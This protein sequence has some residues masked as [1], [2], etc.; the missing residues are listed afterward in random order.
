MSV[1]RASDRIRI[2]ALLCWGAHIVAIVAV[3][4]G[5]L[6][7]FLS[8]FL[9]CSIAVLTVVA[10]IQ[11][12]QRSAAFGRIFWRLAA[13]GFSI[14]TFGLL[15]ATYVDNFQV[16]FGRHTWLVEVFVNAWTAPLVMCLFLDPETEPGGP[17]WR[18][19]LDFAQVGIVFALLSLYSSNFAVGG[20]GFEPWRLALATDV[21]ITAGFFLRGLTTPF[22]P[23]R[24]LFLRFGYF[25]LVAVV[26][27][28]FFVL[29]MPEPPVGDF[30]D[31]IWSLTLLIPLMIA[32]AWED[33][34]HPSA[35]KPA[36]SSYWRLLAT[37]LLPLIFPVLV[38]L[39][40]S[41]IVRGQLVI[42]AAAVLAS[43]GITY[44]RLVLTQREQE[45]SAEALRQNHLL[46]NSIMEGVN[47]VIFVKDLHGRY[48]MINTPG[49]K[50]IGSTVA[51]II[52]KS[53]DDVFPAPTAEAIKA[54][55]A[56]IIRSGK[57]LTYELDMI[58]PSGPR[59]FLTTKSPHRGPQGEIIGLIGVSLDVTERRKFEQQLRQTQKMEA[60]GT[61]SGGIAHD[62]NNL[63]TVIKGYTGLVLDS[64]QDARLRPLVIHIDQAADRASALTRQLLAYSRRQVL[65]PKVINLNSLV[66]NLDKLLQRLI[67]EDIEMKSVVDPSLGSVKADPGQ[68]E[69]VIMNLAVNAR[70]AM[71]KGGSLTL[72][73]ANVDLDEAYTREHPGTA[74][75]RYVMLAVSDSGMGMDSAT[76]A[77]IFEPFFTTKELGRGTGLGLSMVYGIVKQSGGAIEVYS[78]PGHGTTFKVYLP[79]IEEP[80]E[81][82]RGKQPPAGTI[83][84]TETILLVEDDRQVRDLAGAVLTSCGYTVLVAESARAVASKCEQHRGEIHLLLTDVVMPGV[85]GREIA[86]Q[87]LARRPS[88]KVLYMSGY[89]TNAIIHH[90]VLDPGTFF[91]QKPF[92]PASLSAK[93]REVLDHRD[94]RDKG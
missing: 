49:A 26:T 70:D 29:G 8:D 20:Q 85:G 53:D 83:R 16:S 41:Q 43:L 72:E 86:N 71:P 74:P 82:L 10:C 44:I 48:V 91:L 2:A 24:S 36:I 80:A 33:T 5:P 94:G 81:I 61:L 69:Q 77:Q 79:R 17:D 76:Q 56:Q 54:A 15:F 9:Q 38:M 60:I 13:I 34:P 30:F 4:P 73:T 55:D 67:G 51:E 22:E 64:V 42:A 11:A 68:I 19:L 12:A 78:E 35:A 21:L 27:D 88:T 84:G 28:V 57:T 65:Q 47:E 75:G 62:F 7:A 89:T 14:L 52:G 93:V 90:G 59:T 87:V 6:K 31:L 37:Q 1:I 63:L 39:M 50:M 58:F 25:R 46:L 40:A 3:R 66:V 92:T 45:G 32:V 18:R 23:A